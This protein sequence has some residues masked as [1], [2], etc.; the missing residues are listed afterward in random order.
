MARRSKRTE[1]LVGLFLFVGLTLLGGLIVEYG[2]FGDRM[3]GAYT[4]IV[5]FQ[6]ASGVIK[7]SEVRR[8]GVKIGQVAAKPVLG[9]NRRVRV[10]IVIREDQPLPKNAVF[11]IISLTLLGDKAI[12]VSIPDDASSEMLADGDM[13][14]GGGQSGLEAIQSDAQVIAADA[15]ILMGNARTTLLK[16][17]AA[18]DD[19]RAVAG[20][21]T[22]GVETLNEDLL[23]DS[24]LSNFSETLANLKEATHHI[25]EASDDLAPILADARKS[26]RSVAS[27]AEAAEGTFTRASSEMDKIEPALREVP[28]A[29]RSIKTAANAATQTLEGLQNPDG[30][31]GSLATDGEVT[32][33]AKT[34]M[35]N[36]RRYG[37][38]G[39]RDAET[40]DEDDPRNRFRGKRR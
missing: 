28:G 25:N 20:R 33:D 14:P 4:I 31:I 39:Y 32:T 11:Q 36:L 23:S 38:L 22:E 40:F 19:V 21:L 27:A 8:G 1:T 16:L 3:R 18:L 13:I 30:L 7:G 17:D 24:N 26:V 6:D 37:I 5:E 34:F 10:T 2:R 15:R 12:V 35:K 9:Q 29:V